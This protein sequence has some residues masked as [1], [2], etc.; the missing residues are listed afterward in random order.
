LF[1]SLLNAAC[2]RGPKNADH[3][4]FPTGDAEVTRHR[5]HLGQPQPAWLAACNRA[6]LMSFPGLPAAL[7]NPA[8]VRSALKNWFAALSRNP[9]LTGGAFLT[10]LY[11]WRYLGFRLLPGNLQAVPEGWWS[12]FDQSK[13]IESARALAA[14][15]FGAARHWYPV[16][17]ALLGAPFTSWSPAH[18]FVFVDLAALLAT[19]ASFQAFARRLNVG[20]I[21]PTLI[22]SALSRAAEG[23][24]KTG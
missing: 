6:L 7:V 14:L 3:D 10:L 23:F 12:W 20:P 9:T 24:L 15:D 2:R 11:F 4:A 18:P 5:W 1:R 17:Y 8:P 19:F 16:G 13:Y 22:L 21:W